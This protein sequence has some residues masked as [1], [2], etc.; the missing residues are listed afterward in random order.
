MCRVNGLVVECPA[1]LQYL[2]PFMWALYWIALALIVFV[3]ASQW[4]VFR[5]AGKPGWAVI[6][7]VYN[8]VV[9]LRIVNR[10]IWWI[11]LMFIPLVNFVISIILINDLAKSFGKGTGF[12]IGLFFLSFIFLPIL[13][14]GKSQYTKPVRAGV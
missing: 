10:P 12:T 7:P 9:V 6:I 2:A 14:F 4:I 3:I 1:F 11:I 8:F 5:K 13:A